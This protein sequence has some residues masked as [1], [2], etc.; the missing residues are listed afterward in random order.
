MCRDLSREINNVTKIFAFES[1]RNKGWVG[2]DLTEQCP[3][4]LHT[5]EYQVQ[6]AKG[7]KEACAVRE[8]TIQGS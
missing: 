3:R 6:G 5:G 8:N 2:V 1:L 7:L 4:V